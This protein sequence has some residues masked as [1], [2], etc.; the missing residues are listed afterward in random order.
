MARALACALLLTV[1]GCQPSPTFEVT[2]TGSPIVDEDPFAGVTALELRWSRPGLPL[3]VEHITF[4]GSSDLLVHAPPLADGAQLEVAALDARGVVAVGRTAPLAKGQKAAV[5][6]VARLD[7]FA[8]T[9]SLRPAQSARFAASATTLADGVVLFAGG[10]TRG[11]PTLPDASSLSPLLDLY[12]PATGAF[13]VVPSTAFTAR[14]YHAA[15]ATPDGG[16]LLAGGLGMFDALADVVR[17][18]A[19]GV[20]SAA[21]TLPGKRFAAATA[22]LPDGGAL[23]VGGY[24][25]PDGMGGGTLAT[26]A[27]LLGPDGA[28]SSIALP[29]PRA[30][31]A[32]VTLANGDVL[33]TGG[34]DNLGPRSDALYYSATTRTIAALPATGDARSDMLTARVG[35]TATRLPSGA[36]LIYG[37]NDGRA[38]VSAA[39]LWSP[40]LTGF[41]DPSSFNLDPRQRH[42]AVALGDGSVLLTGGESQPQRMA[43]P[44]PVRAL[45]H[46]APTASGSGGV[47]AS[48]FPLTPAR[49]EANLVLLPD[50]SVLYT[51]GAVSDP[52]MLAGGAQIF[53]P[54][55]GSCRAVTP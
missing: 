24:S 55:F 19:H 3:T 49:A 53:V 36:V 44:S 10:A 7:Q 28:A 17:I 11:S 5:A 15:F 6:Y 52:R 45:L 22:P 8:A 25:A 35:H 33:I 4:T 23:L 50:G 26:D 2:L 42:A 12:D 29:L 43:T 1:G 31:A 13:T 34:T 46:F 32:A 41:V 37:G 47:L 40:S 30:F 14:I 48:D 18:D 20:A 54:C 21:G 9:P 27:L 51:G 39:E 16:A 38:S